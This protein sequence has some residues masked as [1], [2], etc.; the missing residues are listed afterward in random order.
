MSGSHPVPGGPDEHQERMDLMTFVWS[1]EES[2]SLGEAEP[3]ELDL[4]VV[5]AGVPRIC[6]SCGVPDE[7]INFVCCQCGKPVH[8]VDGECGSWILDSWHNDAATENE[9]S[10]NACHATEETTPEQIAAWNRRG[11]EQR[12]ARLA[13][14]AARPAPAPVAAPEGF[15]PFLDVP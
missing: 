2:D 7:S 8:Y 1:W 15:D 9:F 6:V 10:C 4:P 13:A 5:A 3:P 11:A 14:E 12:T